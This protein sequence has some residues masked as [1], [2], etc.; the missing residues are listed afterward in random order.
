MIRKAITDCLLLLIHETHKFNGTFELLD[1]MLKII[2]GF[3]IPLKEEH[4]IFFK[5][6]S[7]LY[8][9]YKLQIYILTTF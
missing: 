7:F 5:I 2:S 9:K 4:I 3:D 6:S 1:I 8:I